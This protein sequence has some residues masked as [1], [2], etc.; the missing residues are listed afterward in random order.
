MRELFVHSPASYDGKYHRFTE[1]DMWPKPVQNP[2]PIYAGGN[3]TSSIQRAAELGQGWIP[4]GLTPSEIMQGYEKLE[5]FAEKAGRDPK[6]IRIV[7]EISTTIDL[8]HETA[9]QRYR[10]SPWADHW[11]SLQ[12]TTMK[13]QTTAISHEERGFHGTPQEIVKKIEPYA[14][15]PVRSFMLT[16]TAENVDELLDSLRRFSV[17]VMPSFK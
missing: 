10:R 13:S 11:E 7:P 5:D 3:S 6:S 16:F 9:L 1:I 4:A 14:K 8:S 17:D 2:F 15:T 12:A